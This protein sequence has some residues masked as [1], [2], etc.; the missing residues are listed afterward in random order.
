MITDFI[1]F[2]VF[3]IIV[4]LL[5][6]LIFTFIALIIY[7]IKFRFAKKRGKQYL[8][9]FKEQK[10]KDD[11]FKIERRS[12]INYG[13]YEKTKYYTPSE[14]LDFPANVKTTITTESTEGGNETG[15]SNEESRVRE[16]EAET[17]RIRDEI[18][19]LRTG[20]FTPEQPSINNADKGVDAEREYIPDRT[21]KKPSRDKNRV[22]LHRPSNL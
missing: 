16:L 2:I 18:E 8:E 15:E 14:N 22:K 21:I 6:T 13:N 12:K 1:A 5:L 19:R 7:S 20:E 3:C 4:V 10:K 17:K 9:K 11:Q